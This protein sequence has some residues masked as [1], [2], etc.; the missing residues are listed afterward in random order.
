[1]NKK[2]YDYGKCHVC[3]DQMVEQQVNQEF[4]G[5]SPRVSKGVS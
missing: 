5:S 1:M 3:G 4:C 2:K